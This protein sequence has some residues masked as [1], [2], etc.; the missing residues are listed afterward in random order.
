M[1]KGQTPP[2]GP[3]GQLGGNTLHLS[4]NISPPWESPLLETIAHDNMDSRDKQTDSNHLFRA[5]PASVSARMPC[6][7]STLRSN[8]IGKDWT[9][10]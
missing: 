3:R 2:T 8:E 9:S 10:I 7:E 5:S 6:Y 1:R 4:V